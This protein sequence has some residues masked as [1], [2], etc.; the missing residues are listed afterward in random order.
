MSITFSDGT[1]AGGASASGTYCDRDDM[2][3]VSGADNVTAWADRDNDQ[4]AT[5][6]VNS[7]QAAI[8][9]AED[10]IN[11][12][13]RDGPYP[14]PFS[15]VPTLVKNWAASL[16]VWKLYRGR[17]LRD[18]ESEDSIAGKMEA[19]YHDTRDEI[20]RAVTGTVRLQE[21][22]SDSRPTA[23]VIV[24]DSTSTRRGA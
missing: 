6:I 14:I 18:S 2:G 7:I 12:E 10:F 11:A 13:F 20:D 17:G 1:A 16:A 8:N 5:T 15:P 23:P 22:L 4:N 19:I 21:A 3:D 24:T 9:W